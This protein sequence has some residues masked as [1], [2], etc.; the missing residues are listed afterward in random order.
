[1]VLIGRAR[2]RAPAEIPPG[3]S[4]FLRQTGID[5]IGRH[6]GEFLDRDQASTYR[7]PG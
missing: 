5:R 1:M 3:I 6:S 7:F 2:P 4:C